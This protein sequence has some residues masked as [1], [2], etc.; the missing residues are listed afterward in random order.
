MAG[1]WLK[2]ALDGLRGP[3]GLRE[4]PL[5]RG[6]L[7]ELRPY[8]EVGVRWLSLLQRL[9]LGACLADDMGL[10]KTDPGPRAPARAEGAR[11]RRAAV[12]PCSWSPRR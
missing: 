2:E 4:A 5:P 6:L 3:E 9:G 12:P 10:G 8:Q 7:A 11:R 1:P